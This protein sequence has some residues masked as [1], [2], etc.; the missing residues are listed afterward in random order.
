MDLQLRGF[1]QI[2]IEASTL[3]IHP[4]PSVV[5]MGL[6]KLV[7]IGWFSPSN[8]YWVF[9]FEQKY[10]AHAWS[11]PFF[12][13]GPHLQAQMGPHPSYQEMTLKLRAGFS[14]IW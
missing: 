3:L 2:L 14:N 13:L 12:S 10:L 1:N 6:L 5:P 11:H 9:N 4:R 8:V 7:N